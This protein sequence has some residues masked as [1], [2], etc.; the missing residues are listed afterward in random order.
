M[1]A[2]EM[3]HAQILAEVSTVAVRPG[4]AEPLRAALR[5]ALP[6]LSEGAP[7]EE[8]PTTS[9]RQEALLVEALEALDRAESGLREGGSHD[10]VASD[11]T[12]ARRALG[13][14]VGR[15]VDQDV[16]ASIFEIG[17]AHV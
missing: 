15:G 7:G 16:I 6:R 2:V 9:A 10:L 5:D 13:E 17:R 8:M 1:A 12:D 14:I 4:G 11:L 3:P